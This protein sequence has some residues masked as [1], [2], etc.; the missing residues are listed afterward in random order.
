MTRIVDLKAR[1]IW[2]SR[3]H[4]AVEAEIFLEGGFSGRGSAPTGVSIGSRAARVVDAALAV[5]NSQGEMRTALLEGAAADQVSLDAAL[6]RLDGRPDKSRLGGNAMMAVSLAYA[7]AAAA[8]ARMP[9]WRHLA[10]ERS[11]ALPV[12]QIQIFGG[13]EQAGG[14]VDVQD[15]M[16]IA[17]GAGS[18]NEAL[19]MTAEVYH[20]AGTRLARQGLRQGVADA[21]GHW[22]T[23]KSNE[24]GLAALVQ[25]IEDAGMRPGPDMAIALDIAATQLFRGGRYQLALEARSLD[26]EQ[27]QRML[28]RWI[29]AYPIVSI[30]DP[31][32]ENDSASM[33]SFTRE[34]GARV[35]IVGDDFFCTDLARIRAGVAQA[36]GNAVLIKPDQAGT[37][38]E[39]R[40]AWAA[41][42]EG[43]YGGIAS[44]RS[45]ETEDPAIVH[46]A[47]GWG[48][49]QIRVGSF[50]RSEHMAK[51]NQG[52]RIEESLGRMAAPYPARRL[53]ERRLA[54]RRK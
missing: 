26:P 20:A 18:F 3:G 36:A 41:A 48:L 24:A 23:F 2:D 32:D 44:A 53:F 11:V 30:E 4:P 27:W 29:D 51:W 7:Q 10:G 34:A 46:L 15:F 38:S 35:Q 33:A 31:F 16:V 40:A 12:P 28:L 54:A 19:E 43:G 39:A 21:G 47:L 17:T 50:S 5:R 37:L 49:P 13:G 25:A 42:N 1:R 45:T 52:L 22:P 6:V 9:L 14:R 8:A